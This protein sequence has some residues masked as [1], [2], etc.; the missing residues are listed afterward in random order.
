MNNVRFMAISTKAWENAGDAREAIPFIQRFSKLEEL[1]VVVFDV[2]TGEIYDEHELVLW[3]EWRIGDEAG[4]SIRT[5]ETEM[6]NDDGG[7][8]ALIERNVMTRECG[9]LKNIKVRVGIVGRSG[10][11]GGN[12]RRG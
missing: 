10:P 1:T 11:N 4:V 7:L 2:G 12:T 3:D 5:A 8:M 6:A 9:G